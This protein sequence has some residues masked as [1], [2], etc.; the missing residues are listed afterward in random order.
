MNSQRRSTSAKT[1][2]RIP[3]V[4]TEDEQAALLRRPNP[5]WPTGQRNHLVLQLML[6]VGL[7]L[8]EA[9]ALRWR[10]LDLNTEPPRD[11]RRANSL[12]ACGNGK[13]GQVLPEMGEQG[14]GGVRERERPLCPREQWPRNRPL[15][16]ARED[17]N[18]PRCRRSISFAAG[19]L[20]VRPG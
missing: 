16:Y 1:L 13:A 8:S 6:S 17:L 9:T 2:F 15:L 14:V 7:C 3:D 12:R 18:L 11:W 5:R 10:D 20:R 4:L 19:F